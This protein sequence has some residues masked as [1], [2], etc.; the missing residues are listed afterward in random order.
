MVEAEF[1]FLAVG[2]SNISLWR[3]FIPRNNSLN[4]LQILSLCIFQIFIFIS[5]IKR[6]SLQS[7]SFSYIYGTTS[8]TRS[9]FKLPK[10][11]H[12]IRIIVMVRV[13]TMSPNTDFHNIFRRRF[14]FSEPYLKF[15]RF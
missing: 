3:I 1:I 7:A 2:S 14:E 6:I 15:L 12:H 11:N 13:E 10:K 9:L 8:C 4:F 5:I